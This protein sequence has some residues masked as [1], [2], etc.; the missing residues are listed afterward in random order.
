MGSVGQQSITFEEWLACSAV[1]Y[2]WAD[3]YDNKNW[4]GLRDI[5]APKLLVDYAKVNNA[6]FVDLPAEKYIE[7]MSDPLFLGDPLIVSQHL[8]GATKWEKISDEEVVSHHQSR[9]AH[10]RWADEQ[11]SVVAVKGHGH[12]VVTTFYKKLDGVW[13]WAGIRTKVIWNEYDFEHV[14]VGKAGKDV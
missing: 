3:N 1:L 8:I 13:K 6:K 10:Q 9:A 4:D 7:M 14:F 5:L 12:G 2:D 11:R